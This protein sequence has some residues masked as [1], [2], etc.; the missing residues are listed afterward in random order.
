MAGP[1]LLAINPFKDVSIS[2]SDVIMAYREKLLVSPHVYSV[3]DT[4]Y[5]DM[6]KGKFHNKSTINMYPF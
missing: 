3:A 2:G 1:V 6:M 5:I 4:A